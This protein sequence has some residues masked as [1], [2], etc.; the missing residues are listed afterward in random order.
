MANSK[1]NKK[2]KRS[3][4]KTKNWMY[5]GTTEHM[6]SVGIPTQIDELAKYLEEKLAPVCYGI[7]LHDRDTDPETGKLKNPHY[8]IFFVLKSERAYDGKSL[9]KAFGDNPQ[10]FQAWKSKANNGWSYLCHRTIQAK[11]DGKFQYSPTDVLAGGEV[12]RTDRKTGITSQIPFSYIDKILSIESQVIRQRKESIN[13]LIDAYGRGEI[14]FD[15][16][17][18]NLTPSE[19][20]KV[21]KTLNSASNY[22]FH[23][24]HKHFLERM[25]K[26]D[27]KINILYFYGPT[28][29]GKTHFAKQR[30]ERQYFVSGSNRDI[31]QF[32]SGEPVFIYD[33]ARPTDL[34]YNE[35]LKFLDEKNFEKV[36]G[37]RYSDKK[38]IAHTIIITTPFPPEEFF[39]RCIKKVAENMVIEKNDNGEII[40]TYMEKTQD[41]PDQFY[42][43]LDLI[44]KFDYDNIAFSKYDLEDKEIKA[45]PDST[46]ENKWS[47]KPSE[48]PTE[49]S[50]KTPEEL[51]GELF[52]IPEKGVK[53]DV[54]NIK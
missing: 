52:G 9:G 25:S 48:V 21:E 36:L 1:S 37:S 32:Y 28:W 31:G 33:D 54:I 34:D 17:M 30:Y 19:F 43:R 40:D 41:K 20:A 22:L 12:S 49:S 8:H 51:I 39:Y 46:I 29:T 24:R 6:E 26:P 38:I 11:K 7:I 4:N 27:A 16:V 14:T 53:E 23:Y 5:V 47:K 50:Q 3:S 13:D 42:R 44:A 10:Q 2:P 18:D 35:L 45:I 15:E